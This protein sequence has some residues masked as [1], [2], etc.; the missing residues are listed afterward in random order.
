MRPPNRR[1]KLV[2]TIATRVCSGV[3]SSRGVT[4]RNIENGLNPSKTVFVP[5]DFVVQVYQSELIRRSLAHP[6]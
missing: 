1:K 6:A 2:V 5:S 4:L 3:P